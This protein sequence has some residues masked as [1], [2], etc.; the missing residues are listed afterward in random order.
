MPR[1]CDGPETVGADAYDR[2]EIAEREMPCQ[3]PHCDVPIIEGDVVIKVDE[4]EGMY[5]HDYC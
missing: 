2:V 4:A 1:D 3:N 5:V